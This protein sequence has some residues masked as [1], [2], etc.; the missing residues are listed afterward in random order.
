MRRFVS[1]TLVGLCFCLPADAGILG[2]AQ[3]KTPAAQKKKDSGRDSGV[4][5]TVERAVEVAQVIFTDRDREVIHKHYSGGQ[6]LPPGLAKKGKLPPGLA[7]QL[8]RNGSLPPG[9]QKRYN[10]APLSDDLTHK[11]SPLPSGFLRILIAGKA[12][13]LNR[14]HVVVDI[15]AVVK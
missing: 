1:F 12:V 10:A 2:A 15:L 3:K 5:R 4:Q 6:G 14:D 8:R 9:L 13:I 7:K 11:L